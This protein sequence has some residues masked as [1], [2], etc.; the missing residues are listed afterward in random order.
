MSH[1]NPSA[2]LSAA[3]TDL[4]EEAA[5]ALVRPRWISTMILCWLSR[6]ARRDCARWVCSMNSRHT[7]WQA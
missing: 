4:R 2:A 6:I 3:L 7:T 5:L 1:A